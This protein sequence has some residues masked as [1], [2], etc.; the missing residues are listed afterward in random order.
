MQGKIREVS[1]CRAATFAVYLAVRRTVSDYLRDFNIKQVRHMQRLPVGEQPLSTIV[2]AGV[3]SSASSKAE[4]APRSLTISFSPNCLHR[5]DG[6]GDPRA[7]L[8][9]RAQFSECR[10]LGH[11]AN[12]AEQVIRERHASK[13]RTRLESAV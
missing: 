5:R 10:S 6:W 13:R 4:A 7:T 2:S 9:A 12:L 11:L 1:E 8:Q 3:R